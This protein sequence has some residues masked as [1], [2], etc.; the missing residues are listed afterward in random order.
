VEQELAF[1]DLGALDVVARDQVARDLGADL[2]VDR[3][4]GGAD[5]LRSVIGTSF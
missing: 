5:P 4:L 2:G 3:A 1:L